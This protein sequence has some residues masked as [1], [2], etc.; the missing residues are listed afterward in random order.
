MRGFS[1]LIVLVAL[2]VA[3]YLYQQNLRT[4][5]QRM[6][7]DS[8]QEIKPRL[9]QIGRDVERQT[10]LGVRRVDEAAR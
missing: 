5:G 6:G 2:A 7:A 10:E 1:I 8:P 9:E 3:G 4:T